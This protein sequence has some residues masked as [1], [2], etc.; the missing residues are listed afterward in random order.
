MDFCPRAAE[1]ATGEQVLDFSWLHDL[2]PWAPAFH[3]YVGSAALVVSLIGNIVA[4]YLYLRRR[5]SVFRLFAGQWRGSL[6]CGR[7]T[8][9]C[10]ATFHLEHGALAGSIY[11]EGQYDEHHVRGV[12]QLTNNLAW[13]ETLQNN[14]LLHPVR[15]KFHVQFQRRLHV[16]HDQGH[17]SV[18]DIGLVYY[19]YEFE[20]RKRFFNPR[21]ACNVTT[22][23][24]AEGEEYFFAGE[25]AKL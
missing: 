6:H 5:L 4:G 14:S 19:W 17:H 24:D 20:V 8:V 22:K 3:A 13:F 11:Y 10:V 12:D 18:M 21:L 1:L 7:G 25:L 15:G 9:D 16:F 2:F 23:A